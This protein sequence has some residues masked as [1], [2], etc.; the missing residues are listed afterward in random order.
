MKNTKIETTVYISQPKS[1]TFID[2]FNNRFAGLKRLSMDG[3]DDLKADSSKE[4]VKVEES[5][6]SEK[7]SSTDEMVRI[8]EPVRED[9]GSY[10]RII[11]IIK[12]EL[13]HITF[14]EG[15]PSIEELIPQEIHES[16][17]S[18]AFVTCG[19]PAMVDQVRYYC[20]KNVSNKERKR[21][22]FYEQIQVWA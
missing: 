1:Y 10:H 18:I 19:H 9:D 8:D 13:S 20:A 22:Y 5:S 17:G 16:N 6:A 2:E 3:L 12:S 14:I 4:D 21:V 11:D 7:Q 15:R